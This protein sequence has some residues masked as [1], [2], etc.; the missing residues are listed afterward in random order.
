M[1]ALI[2]D[3]LDLAKLETGMGI[4]L[5]PNA[6]NPLLQ[7]SLA[8]FEVAARDK[9]IE[10]GFLRLPTNDMLLIDPARMSQVFNNLIS[11]AIKYTP[12]G[13]MVIISVEQQADQIH[14]VVRD[15]GLGIPEADIPKLFNKFFRVRTP[16]HAEIDGT[17][18]GLAIVREIVAQHQGE[19]RVT[20]Q[21]GAG[22]AFRVILPAI[23]KKTGLLM[24]PTAQD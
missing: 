23:R 13:G 6:L 5:S 20:S 21:L 15:T 12:P 16:S 10:L 9:Q 22:S 17:G 4:S 18:L 8:N 1:L 14:V 24:P 19:V 2:T 11:N 3:L 7:A